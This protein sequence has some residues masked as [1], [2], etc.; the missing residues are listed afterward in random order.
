MDINISKK[1]EKI[2]VL[3]EIW[4]QIPHSY[5]VTNC[6]QLV[7]LYKNFGDKIDFYSKLGA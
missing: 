3:F 7:H 2:K 5:A 4:W 1:Q 6:F